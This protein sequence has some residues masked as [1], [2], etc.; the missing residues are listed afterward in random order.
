MYNRSS[1]DRFFA[2][3]LL[4]GCLSATVSCGA[5]TP[6]AP[7]GPDSGIPT[8]SVC[9][10][11]AETTWTHED[12]SAAP[13]P[14]E[15]ETTIAKETPDEHSLYIAKRDTEMRFTFCYHNDRG[16]VPE[17]RE[18]QDAIA[19]LTGNYLCID[20]DTWE[21]T[22]SRNPFEFLI[23]ETRRADV[24]DA[25]EDLA[26]NQCRFRVY[27]DEADSR[28]RVVIAFLDYHVGRCAI[29]YLLDRYVTE[30]A[31]FLPENLDEIVTFQAESDLVLTPDIAWA[32][33]PFVLLD[34][35][36]YYLYSTTW[37]CS[38][39]RS[40]RLDGEWSAPEVCVNAPADLKGDC[41]APE[42][43]KY[44][45]G[46]YMF[47]TYRSMSCDM[48]GVSVFRSD[49]PQG[50][51]EEW[52]DG[53]VTPRDWDSIDG[54][55][56]V[57]ENGQPWMVFVHQF[58]SIPDGIGRMD[59][60]KMSADLTHFISEPIELFGA[61]D[62]SWADAVVTDGCFLYRTHDG[63]LLM[64]WSNWDDG[65][66]CVGIAHSDTGSI[67]GPWIQEDE[68]LFSKRYFGRY[69]G[70]HGMIFRDSDGTMYLSIHSPNSQTPSRVERPIFV[71]ITEKH[72]TLVIDD[73]LR[74]T[75]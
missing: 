67:E 15:P 58:T 70:G 31:F 74:R 61:K 17:M 33:D 23:G 72:G 21:N 6:L 52:S 4:L 53:I 38:V 14:Q 20:T 51:F 35:G 62:P 69:D 46:Y 28:I 3:L 32:R 75:W 1:L 27:R 13:V 26:Y 30:D 73:G 18:L 50:P 60:A 42:V 16:R 41:W 10:D 71:R 7:D 59:A 12:T 49:S 65:G 39:N 64:L 5:D 8:S 43:Y 36:V 48:L 29:R 24:Q 47:T 44:G 25:Y 68:R 56:F 2:S 55:L 63:R 11:P 37:T 40:G 9:T 22:D 57:D 66:Y 54:T 19:G 34:D 45:D